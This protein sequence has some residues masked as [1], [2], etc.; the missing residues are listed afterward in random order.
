VVAVD[1]TTEE[2]ML[3]HLWICAALVSL[4][5]GPVYAQKQE[6]VLRHI[7]VAGTDFNLVLAEPKPGGNV[8]PDLGN[9]PDALIVH[10]HGGTLALVFEDAKQ[11]MEVLDLLRSP[12][13]A[14]HVDPGR[15]GSLHPVALYIVSKSLGLPPGV[16]RMALEEFDSFRW[17]TV[18]IDRDADADFPV[19][20]V[21]ASS[22]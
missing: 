22:R 20:Q 17:K 10:L 4:G 14:F 15:S 7:E 3:K 21:V 2:T 16:E 12:A 19:A 11:M 9:T 8:L 18:L 13:I 5:M 6:A 1:Q